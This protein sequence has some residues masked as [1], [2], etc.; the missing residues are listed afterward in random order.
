[1]GIF[2]GIGG[3]INQIPVVGNG[4]TSTFNDIG[5]AISP[6]ANGFMNF[7]TSFLTLG[8]S[9]NHAL[10]NLAGGLV[11]IVNS[12]TFLYLVGG[13]IIVGGIIALKSGGPSKFR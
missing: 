9:L 8:T 12:P 2:D 1:M 4:I 5:S 6:I 7:G 3:L 13:V 11:N 10:G